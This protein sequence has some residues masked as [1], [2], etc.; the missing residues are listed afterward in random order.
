MY[1]IKDKY[2]FLLDESFSITKDIKGVKIIIQKI[3]NE[4]KI[5]KKNLNTPLTFIDKVLMV[6]YKQLFDFLDNI[7]LKFLDNNTTLTFRYQMKNENIFLTNIQKIVGVGKYENILD[8]NVYEEYA[9][10]L[11]VKLPKI[12]Y[13][14]SLTPE[15]KVQILDN[16][17]STNSK[18]DIKFLLNK[19]LNINK[20]SS[21][22]VD[23]YIFK[24]KNKS[25]NLTLIELP[26]DKKST[27]PN[28]LY[29]IILLDF[30]TF[31]NN[32]N[33]IN[34]ELK[35]DK[36]DIRYVELI[37]KVFIDF[38]TKYESR[39]HNM[40]LSIPN[41]LQDDNFSTNL[42]TIK[43]SKLLELLNNPSYEIIFKIILSA[44]R[45]K[46]RKPYGILT[47]DNIVEIN[48]TIDTILKKITIVESKLITYEQLVSE[49]YIVKEC[50]SFNTL[51]ENLSTDIIYLNESNIKPDNNVNNTIYQKDLNN[52][53]GNYN[54]TITKHKKVN[55]VDIVIING[56][57]WT[58][59]NTKHIQGMGNVIVIIDDN[60]LDKSLIT[61]AI[62]TVNP[63]VID[64]IFNDCLTPF[65]LFNNL[66]Y[67][68]NS[69]SIY[70]NRYKE[71]KI[72]F[73]N[74]YFKDSIFSIEILNTAEIDKVLQDFNIWKMYFDDSIH[75]LYDSYKKI[76]IDNEKT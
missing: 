37:S 6:G 49:D 76:F 15:Q 19:V 50:E 63:N 20:I 54:L 71:F 7:N 16:E 72:I 34:Y 55:D 47:K 1:N 39:Y 26:N 18:V 74:A 53:L 41:Y 70:S 48:K 66:G 60:C 64:V 43:D 29:T 69:L 14:K 36:M 59:N 13:F 28:D 75:F 30:I 2:K 56:N 22:D 73:K 9:N 5:F 46:R 27:I 57:F 32:L 21:K 40:I 61:N 12:Y 58:V 44:F 4:V 51:S 62:K 33:L 65:S 10:I 24:Y 31:F 11:N 35:Q 42:D 8:N 3:N 23:K 38:I 25:Y 68:I 17:V 67:N 45:K 52:T